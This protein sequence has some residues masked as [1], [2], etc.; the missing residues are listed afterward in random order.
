VTYRGTGKVVG[1]TATLTA[2]EITSDP[3][4]A[5][6]P[7]GRWRVVAWE[8]KG[9]D[10]VDGPGGTFL[11]VQVEDLTTGVVY[12][13]AYVRDPEGYAALGGDVSVSITSNGCTWATRASAPVTATEA[14]G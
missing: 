10:G 1:V 7:D 12:G 9:D 14:C 8:E 5:S 2:T 6:S 13:P 4:V 3:S 11:I